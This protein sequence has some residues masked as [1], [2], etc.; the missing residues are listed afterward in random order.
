MFQLAIEKG[1][2]LGNEVGSSKPG[3]LLNCPHYM[4]LY[5]VFRKTHMIIAI[6]NMISMATTMFHMYYL[7][8]K[9]CSVKK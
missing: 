5:R 2:G 8:V 3:V 1:A 7:A 4:R 9:L 6:G